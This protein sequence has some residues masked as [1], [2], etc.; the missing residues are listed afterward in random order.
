MRLPRLELSLTGKPSG[1]TVGIDLDADSVAAVE[2]SGSDGV[3]TAAVQ[4]LPA[5]AMSGGEILDAGAIR[6]ALT[7]LYH[8]SRLSRQ[9]RLAVASQGVAFRIMRLPLI[10]NP[11]QLRS[12]VRFQAGE[13]ISMPLD[14]AVLD[15]QIVGA[16]VDGDG[17]RQIDVAVVAARRDYVETLLGIAKGAGLDP[18][19]IDLAAFGMIRAMAGA[20][21]AP[22]NPDDATLQG[23]AYVPASLYCSLGGITNLA[24]AQ[25]RTCLFSRVAQ[26]SVRGIAEELV[27]NNGMQLEHAEQWLLHVGF[28]KPAAE[29]EGDP[30]IVAAVRASLDSNVTRLSDELRLSLDYYGAQEGA[31]PT[32]S[33]YLC[34]WGAAIP[35][36]ADR[37]GADLG[38]PVTL[39]T[40][41]P[42]S[43]YPAQQAARLT[44]PYGLALEF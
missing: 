15:H 44:L 37:I 7:E 35:G 32:E 26:F 11:D 16:H 12:A 36:L 42:L 22:S 33:V 41:T 17:A 5:G 8:G 1:P 4:P 28:D 34:G 30:A 43:T 40:P 21:P 20:E 29:I 14:S 31:A 2:P 10:E 25:G 23:G 19:G 39:A 9:V 3:V 38:R 6:D 13:E 18:V 24:I 27:T